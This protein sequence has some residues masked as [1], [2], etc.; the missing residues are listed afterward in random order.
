MALLLSAWAVGLRLPVT[1]VHLRSAVP[2]MMVADPI[3]LVEANLKPLSRAPADFNSFPF[4]FDTVLELSIESISNL[5]DGVA[6][7]QLEASERGWVVFVPFV[8][9]G[10]RVRAR[11]KKNFAG[12]SRAELV[13]VIESSSLRVAPKCKLFGV[14]GGC[15]YQH[16][17]YAQ[18]LEW[19]RQQ[20]V[21][22]L[23]R[24][25][26]V[27]H[28]AVQ[29]LVQPAVGS[30]RQWHYRSKITPHWRRAGAE[31]GAPV[32][33]GDELVLGFLATADRSQLVG[34]S[35]CAIATEPINAALPAATDRLRAELNA[36]PR[37]ATSRTGSLLLRHVREGIVEDAAAP[38]SEDV[39]GIVF[40]FLAGD[41]FQNNP[42]VLPTFV[43]HVVAHARGGDAAAVAAST[44]GDETCEGCEA[45]GVSYLIDAYSGCGL[46]ALS[47][48]RHFRQ[49]MGI[50]V[51]AQQAAVARQ[52]ALANGISNAEFE[53][54][55]AERIFER[56][57]FDGRHS[58]VILDPPRRGCDA[59]FLRQLLIF[60]PRR[61]VYVSCSADTQARDLK[62]L[63]AAGYV[64]EGLTPFDLFPHTR[65]IETVATLSWPDASAPTP[66]LPV[67]R[68]KANGTG[69]RRRGARKRGRGSGRGRKR[70]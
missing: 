19:K 2:R 3:R 34:V 11:I 4:A 31:V 67:A 15:Q 54:G 25:G 66:R 27:E 16:V 8:I 14:C 50:E 41:F 1:A 65:H 35:H 36:A 53:A 48:S 17:K 55:S 58:A 42:F 64:L 51:V 40:R 68:V 47:A 57:P 46:F 32:P 69:G 43:E 5:G 52:N 29:H 10:E 23:E 45:G 63:I 56:V 21:D 60:A 59:T 33:D 70:T 37:D 62:V 6:R 9:P 38:V 61:I 18:Q 12:H 39:G 49:V 26:G 20:V 22:V 30:P 44:S 13:E 28:D 24:L 7:V